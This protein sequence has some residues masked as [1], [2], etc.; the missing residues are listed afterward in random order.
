MGKI[1]L[2]FDENKKLADYDYEIIPLLNNIP[3]DSQIKALIEEYKKAV[4]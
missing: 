4:R 1:I 2:R 3:D